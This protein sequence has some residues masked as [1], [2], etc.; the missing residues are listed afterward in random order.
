L[1][2]IGL[3]LQK[4]DEAMASMPRIQYS[5]PTLLGAMGVVAIAVIALR[6]GDWFWSRILFTLTL[7]INLSAALGAIYQTGRGRAFWI[8]FGLFGWTCWLIVNTSYLRI[9]EHQFFASEIH[10][11]LKDYVP[12]GNEGIVISP[13]PSGIAIFSFRQIVHAIFGLLFAVIGGIIGCWLC[14]AN[15]GQQPGI[16]AGEK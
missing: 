3:Y 5:L 7:A 8:G 12:E 11:M 16:H 6:T 9:A 14:P 4:A 1:A 2:V 10:A 13:G 15:H